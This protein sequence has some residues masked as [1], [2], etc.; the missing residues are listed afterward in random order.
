MTEPLDPTE[1]LVAATPVTTYELDPSSLDAMIARASSVPLKNRF[2]LLRTWQMRA[3]SAVAAA[4]LV[5]TGV[6]VSLGGAPQGLTVFA[7]SNASSVAGPVH[8]NVSLAPSAFAAQLPSAPSTKFVVGPR[9]PT[10]PAT[11]A[12]FKVV[13]VTNPVASVAGIASALGSKNV[14]VTKC[15]AKTPGEWN[16]LGTLGV[17][18]ASPYEYGLCHA[19]FVASD[20]PLTWT[21]NVKGTKCPQPSTLAIGVFYSA[22]RVPTSFNDHAASMSQLVAWSAPLVRSLVAHQLI[23]AG[24]STTPA[25]FATNANIV[26]YPLATANGVVTNQ[27]EEFQFSDAGS[28]IYATGPL[29]TVSLESTYPVIS[30]TAGVALLEPAPKV[31]PKGVNP[32]GPMQSATTTTINPGGPMIPATTTTTL[33][34]PS[35]T[36]KTARLGYELLF[37]ANGSAIFVPQYIY[38]VNRG[39]DQRVLALNPSYYRIQTSK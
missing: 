24:M 8:Q 21:Y 4:A 5:V 17:V 34:A 2:S 37:L 15:G 35:V 20:A 3:G 9:L 30:P 39:V 12:V 19:S 32:G 23:P 7:L 22:C 33:A 25:T 38:A 13:S 6:V 26:Y 1:L 14:T 27:F 28:L 11:L 31:S 10:S 36:L 18:G 16:A 29:A